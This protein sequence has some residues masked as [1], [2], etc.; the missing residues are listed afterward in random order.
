MGRH[1]EKTCDVG[2]DFKRLS[3]MDYVDNDLLQGLVEGIVTRAVEDLQLTTK[4]LREHKNVPDYDE[5]KTRVKKLD[6]EVKEFF[7]SD[8]F[9]MLVDVVNVGDGSNVIKRIQDA[10]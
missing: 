7:R 3:E 4:W 9:T 8:W 2:K 1:P 10:S 6:H 5:T